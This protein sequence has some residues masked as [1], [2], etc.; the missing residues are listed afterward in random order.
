MPQYLELLSIECSLSNLPVHSEAALGEPE[1]E[2]PL[3]PQL[4]HRFK[5]YHSLWISISSFT[6]ARD[7]WLASE[8]GELNFVEIESSGKH[9]E[10]K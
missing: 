6:R 10:E 8:I 3:L 5:P 9:T 4:V 1:E 2:F 7:Q